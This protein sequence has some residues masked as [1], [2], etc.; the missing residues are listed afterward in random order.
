[1]VVRTSIFDRLSERRF[2]DEALAREQARQAAAQAEAAALLPVPIPVTPLV[3]APSSLNLGGFNFELPDSFA[4]RDVDFSIER[5]G[6]A[7]AMSIRRR[8]VSENDELDPLFDAALELLRKQHPQARLI[9]RY[10]CLF[11][12]SEA[13]ALDYSFKAGAQDRHGRLVGSLVPLHGA[14]QRQWLS[15]ACVIDPSQ[16]ALVTWLLDFDRM[17]AAVAGT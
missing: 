16:P 14:D 11:A 10:S 1:M 15:V 17:L 8:D 6:Q 9:R 4:F 7:V 2:A 12:G 13:V 3:K 5:D